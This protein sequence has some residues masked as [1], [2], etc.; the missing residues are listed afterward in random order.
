MVPSYT[1]STASA[2]HAVN[3]VVD[4]IPKLAVA[5]TGPQL[6]LN[7]EGEEEGRLCTWSLV[8]GTLVLPCLKEVFTLS[9]VGSAA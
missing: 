8:H 6:R 7:V 5:A 4:G 2:L 9:P 1:S 3:G